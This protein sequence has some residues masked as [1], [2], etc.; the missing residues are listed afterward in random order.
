MIKIRP[1]TAT[2]VDPTVDMIRRGAWGDRR[3]FLDFATTQPQCIPVVADD[4]GEIVGSGVGTANGPVG[5]IGAIFVDERVRRRGIGRGLTDAVIAGLEAAGCRTLALVASDEGRQLYAG[6][7]FSLQTSYATLEAFGTGVEAAE[8]DAVRP[9][10]GADLDAMAMLD[11]E[12]TGEDRRH[13]LAR[14]ATAESARVLIGA[15]GVVD[16]FTVRPPWGGGATIARSIDDGVRI[17]EARRAGIGLERKV[18]AGLPIENRA[19]IARLREL[20]WIRSWNAPRMARGAPIDWRPERIWGQ[21]AMA[22]G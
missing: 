8:G 20:G 17:L 15:S 11:R 14:F 22:L 9:F 7:G 1:M 18:R 5:W 16:A 4:D 21:F 6:M 2:D 19:G 12:A 13:L 3:I 10:E